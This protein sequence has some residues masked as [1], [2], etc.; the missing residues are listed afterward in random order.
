MLPA[1][2]TTSTLFRRIEDAFT[3]ALTII[4]T[5]AV[6]II[7]TAKWTHTLPPSRAF[8]AKPL[9]LAAV[10]FVRAHRQIPAAR[11]E[12]VEST[13]PALATFSSRSPASAVGP[14]S[15]TR[16]QRLIAGAD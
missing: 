6:L 7:G 14:I 15:V 10:A 13:S 16:D 1:Q 9:D 4:L 5:G 3:A 2:K 12:R 8:A 11:V